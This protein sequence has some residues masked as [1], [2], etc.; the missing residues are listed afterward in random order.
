METRSMTDI[1]KRITT[2]ENDCF[3]NHAEQY[4]GCLDCAK[5]LKAIITELTEQN[6]KLADALKAAQDIA[7]AGK[8]RSQERL[9][10]IEKELQ[11][12]NKE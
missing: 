10:L 5:E 3:D 2:F 11:E 9:T 1:Q 8:A 6:K 7:K 12:L 4:E